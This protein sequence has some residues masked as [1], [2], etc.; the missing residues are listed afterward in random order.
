M[1][2]KLFYLLS[3]DSRKAMLR[4]YRSKGW[5]KRYY[6]EPQGMLLRRLSQ[7]TGMTMEEVRDTLMKERE[8]LLKSNG[9]S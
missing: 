6:Y 1:E 8:Y 3:T 2:I 7:Q 5:E 9:L 4:T